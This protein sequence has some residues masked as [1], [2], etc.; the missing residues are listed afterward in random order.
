MVVFGAVGVGEVELPTTFD[1]ELHSEL[2]PFGLD[3]LVPMR[4]KHQ[5][6]MPKW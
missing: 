1:G 3:F 2:C 4:V 5:I 6:S